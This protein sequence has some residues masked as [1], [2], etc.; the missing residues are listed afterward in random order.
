MKPWHTELFIFV[1]FA[2]FAFYAFMVARWYPEASVSI[3]VNTTLRDHPIVGAA[4]FLAIGIVIG[5]ILWPLM[6]P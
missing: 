2:V 4:G 5:H 3:V 1:W 6:R